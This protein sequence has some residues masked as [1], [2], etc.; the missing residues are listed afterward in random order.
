MRAGCVTAVPLRPV[1]NLRGQNALMCISNSTRLD[2]A[3]T[4]FAIT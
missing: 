1:C 2:S 4:C 3:S